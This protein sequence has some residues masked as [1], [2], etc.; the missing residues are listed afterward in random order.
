[1]VEARDAT[2]AA[3]IKERLKE[4]GFTVRG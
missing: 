4:A 3:E 1:V 2:H